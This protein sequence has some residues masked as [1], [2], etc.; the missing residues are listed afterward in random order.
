MYNVTLVDGSIVWSTHSLS[1]DEVAHY[2]RIVSGCPNG[3]VELL[4]RD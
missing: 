3:K 2:N 4:I 1:S